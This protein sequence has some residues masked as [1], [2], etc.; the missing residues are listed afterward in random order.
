VAAAARH[1]RERG[2]AVNR[3][4]LAVGTHPDDWE[5]GAG[6]TLVKHARLGDEVRILVMTR[7]EA[8]TE[9]REVRQ[10]EAEAAAA[11]LGA[12]ITVTALPDTMVAEK[13]A[14]D[15]IEAAVAGWPPD[16]AYTH[17]VHD[18]HQDH[19][20]VAM[21]SRVALRRIRKLYAY[22]SPSATTAFSPA[23][24]TDISLTLGSKL[25][26]LRF[27]KSQ[28][29]REYM[30]DGFAEATARYWGT[31]SGGCWAAEAMEVIFD[32]DYSTTGF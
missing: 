1:D 27:H 24:F 2:P 19:R 12:A 11:W 15:A 20:A 30:Q 8:G 18:T 16:I 25:E 4:V 29:G 22:Q 13:P 21:A 10:T 28:A 6:G 3:R 17:S 7:G 31:R 32:R 9:M 14:I 26:L 5:I 23:R